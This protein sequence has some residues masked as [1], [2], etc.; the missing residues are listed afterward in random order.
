MLST[1][2]KKSFWTV[3][4]LLAF[5]C[6]PKSESHEPGAESSPPQSDNVAAADIR[7]DAWSARRTFGV[8]WSW[9]TA[10]KAETFV[11][12]EV[13]F[14][15]PEGKA[16]DS[17]VDIE[18][19]PWMPSMGHGTATDDQQISPVIGSPGKFKIKGIYFIMGGPWEIRLKATVN[20]SADRAALKVG[21]E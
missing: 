14:I 11:N 5:G 18:I 15:T 20:G 12:A 17:V 16:P 1:G 7:A 19:D 13:T 6:G 3:F 21:V 8:T 10:V 9:D 4:C 2:L